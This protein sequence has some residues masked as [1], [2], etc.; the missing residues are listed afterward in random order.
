MR[1]RTQEKYLKLSV[2]IITLVM[3]VLRFLLNENG[4]VSPDSIRYMRQANVFPIIE[5]TTAP[6]FYPLFIKAFSVLA[7]EFWASKIVGILSYLFIIFF[8]WKKKFYFRE[9]LLVGGLFSMVSL[10]AATLSEALFLP[11][12][13]WFFYIS[14]KVLLDEYSKILA[15]ILLS[16][17]LIFLFNIRYSGL[18]FMGGIFSFGLLNFKKNYA[19]IYMISAFIGFIF[20]T[21]Y[22]IFF[23]DVFN[24]D[25]VKKFLEISLKSTSTLVSE[26]FV[27]I[28]TSFNP[29]IHIPNPNGG[30]LN[31]AILGIGTFNIALIIF[32]FIKNKLSET[33]KMITF[34]SIFGIFCS[35]FIQYVYQ[36]DALDYRLLAPF[37]FGIWL[38][39]FKKLHQIFGKLVFVITFLSFMTGFVF[40]WLS[41]GDYLE[42]RAA[43]KEYLTQ[44]N[45]L[46]KKI[47]F[48][49]NKKDENFSSVQIAELISTINPRIYLTQKDKDSLKNSVLTQYKVENNVKIKKNKFQ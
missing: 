33:E 28:T 42:N 12:L 39:Y 20:V 43:M 5:N 9:S 18:F 1:N 32:I 41:K 40:T 4:R 49:K 25:Y 13:F 22:K 2:F 45:L 19:K 36:T 8:A 11:F 29:F 48:Y 30:I 6:L 10:F 26:F 31:V 35:F 27:A 21:G 46:Q 34:L 17:S 3:I 23:I 37:T 38:I 47:Y 15:V 16:L 44:E 7:D 24:Q 14:R